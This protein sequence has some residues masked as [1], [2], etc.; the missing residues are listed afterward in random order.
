MRVF[1]FVQP[2][3]HAIKAA[4]ASGNKLSGGQKQRIA[5]ARVMLKDAPI[6]VLDEATAFVDPENEKKMNDAIE[7]IIRDKTVIVIAHK[8]SSIARA[9][10][11]IVMDDGRIAAQGTQDALYS[12]CEKYRRL[13]NADKESSCWSLKGSGNNAAYGA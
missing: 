2:V 11:I 8:M 1:S 9:D 12:K 5:F 6:I 4:G 13:W 10:K 3:F 7:E